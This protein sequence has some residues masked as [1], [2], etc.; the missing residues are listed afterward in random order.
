MPTLIGSV[1]TAGGDA[2]ADSDGA[3]FEWFNPLQELLDAT[4]EGDPVRSYWCQTCASNWQPQL[5]NVSNL[6]DQIDPIYP[7]MEAR[8]VAGFFAGSFGGATLCDMAG[9]WLY[10]RWFARKTGRPER[11]ACGFDPGE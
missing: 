3:N 11:I 10:A 8:E 6:F 1:T 9:Q 7:C 2:F 5:V 4:P